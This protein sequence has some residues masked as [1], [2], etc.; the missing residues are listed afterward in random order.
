MDEPIVYEVTNPS[1]HMIKRITKIV[2]SMFQRPFIERTTLSDFLPP[3]CFSSFFM[4]GLLF[5]FR[6]GIDHV[7]LMPQKLPSFF[8]HRFGTLAQLSR[9]LIQVIKGLTAAL[10]QQFARF[11]AREQRDPPPT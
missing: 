1:A 2:Q 5:G 7:A 8:D 11:F 10:T 4:V 6:V 3:Q 9:M